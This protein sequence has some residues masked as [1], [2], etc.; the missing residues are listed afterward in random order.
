M[1]EQPKR[2]SMNDNEILWMFDLYNWDVDGGDVTDRNVDSKQ[3]PVSGDKYINLSSPRHTE[4]KIQKK[5]KIK[6]QDFFPNFEEK[7]WTW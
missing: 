7:S 1:K 6:H 5:K 4:K 3:P 2:N